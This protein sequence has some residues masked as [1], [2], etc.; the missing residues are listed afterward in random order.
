[1]QTNLLM[2]PFMPLLRLSVR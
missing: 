1:M 2:I